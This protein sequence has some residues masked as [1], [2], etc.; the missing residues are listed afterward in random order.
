M[1][2]RLPDS[3]TQ[4][5]Q[6]SSLINAIKSL[7][8]KSLPPT[9][10]F[11]TEKYIQ[12]EPIPSKSRGKIT[13][14]IVFAGI[15]LFTYG[16]YSLSRKFHW[17][18]LLTFLFGFLLT[19]GGIT[20]L[21]IEKVNLFKFDMNLNWTEP[22][23]S[24]VQKEIQPIKK[25]VSDL[26]K[27]IDGHKLSESERQPTPSPQKLV[28]DFEKV[29]IIFPFESAN[30]RIENP[31]ENNS[32]KEIVSELIDLCKKGKLRLLIV[33]GKADKRPLRETSRDSYESNIELSFKRA[34]FIKN[35]LTKEVFKNKD[36]P[37]IKI[38]ASGPDY[39][40]RHI[41]EK[42]M[43]YDRAVIVYA[44]IEKKKV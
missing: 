17:W 13:L 2:E 27:K 44:I 41:E 30:H 1:N 42:F 7:S 32:I 21:Q 11:T 18:K 23:L 6:L 40:D 25:A 33:V 3:K 43:A 31:W 15:C 39:I 5:K 16:I 36:E 29:G 37:K 24:N 12:E 8:S 9:K 35:W 28:L 38:I 19:L 4:E 34:V 22:D 10:N 14:L 26:Q 20:F